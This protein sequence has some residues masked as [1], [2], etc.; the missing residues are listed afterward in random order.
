[1]SLPYS[2]LNYKTPVEI[3]PRKTNGGLYTGSS[4]TGNWGNFPVIPDAVNYTDNLLSADPPKGYQYQVVSTNRPGNNLTYFPN[5]VQC[6]ANDFNN[7][8]PKK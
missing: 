4:A 1:M 7:L 5:Y 6:D 3:P 8:C 2:F